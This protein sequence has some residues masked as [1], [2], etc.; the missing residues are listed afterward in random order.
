MK[1]QLI[2]SVFVLMI[3]ISCKKEKNSLAS[4][5][6]LDPCLGVYDGSSEHWSISQGVSSS[7]IKKVTVDVQKSSLDSCLNLTITYNDTIVDLKKDLKF[8][9]SGKY[10]SQWGSASTAGGLTINFIA[11]SL[12]Y[13]SY[14][15]GGIMSSYGTKFSIKKK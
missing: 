3:F 7:T 6:Y 14:Q 5:Y 8:S 1:Q 9:P 10:Y 11:D 13:S 2:F 15:S 4:S 12:K